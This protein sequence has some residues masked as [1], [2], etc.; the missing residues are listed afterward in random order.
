MSGPKRKAVIVTDSISSLTQAMGQEYSVHVVPIHI[1]F[2]TDS[3]RDDIDLNAET[4]YRMLREN[5]QLPT[6]SQPTAMDFLQSYSSVVGEADAIVSIH[7]SNK[8]SATVDSARAACKEMP[9][10]PI[11]VVDCQTLSMGQGLIVIAA[12]RAAAAGQ[13]AA[14]IVELVEQ[15]MP[16]TH[17]LFT[18]ETLEYLR[19]GGRIGGATALL[20]SALKI[21]PVLH[22]ANG[23]VEPLEKPRTRKRAVGRLLELMAERVNSSDTL[24]AA[25]LHCDAQA[26]AETLAEEVAA[27]F[28][29]NELIVAEAGPTIG[30]HGGPG[31]LGVTFYAD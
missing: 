24:N 9:D 7:P 25:V 12:A 16:K 4:F 15:L 2:G 18:V 3:Y 19:R 13:S 5:K 8:I 22:I 26:E 10:V 23:Q 31:T 30:T 1:F 6:T 11:H 20:G 27:H 29:C 21:K 28:N 17:V 14:E